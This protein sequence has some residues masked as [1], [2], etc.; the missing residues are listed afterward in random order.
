MRNEDFS[1]EEENGPLSPVP[2]RFDEKKKRTFVGSPE[3]VSPEML[4]TNDVGAEG[5][6]WALGCIVYKIFTGISPFDDKTQFLVF[7]KITEL[8]YKLSY[9]VPCKVVN[10]IKSLLILDTHKRLGVTQRGITRIN[11]RN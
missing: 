3:Y 8:N 5:D 11:H 6:L 1:T 10:L 4:R 2:T 9:T 7:N